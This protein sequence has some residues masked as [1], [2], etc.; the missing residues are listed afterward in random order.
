MAGKGTQENISSVTNI[1][2]FTMKGFVVRGGTAM[3]QQ[4]ENSPRKYDRSRQYHA[5]AE[6]IA[7]QY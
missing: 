6:Q 5:R 4:V 7:E 2:R 3:L 1:G